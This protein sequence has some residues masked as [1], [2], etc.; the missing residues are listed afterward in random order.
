MAA[1]PILNFARWYDRIFEGTLGSLREIAARAVPPQEGIQIL[2]IGCGTGSQLAIYNHA[3]CQIYGIDLSQ[4]MLRIAKSKLGDRA[5]LTMGDALQLPH[6]EQTFDLVISSLFIHQ[7]DPGQRSAMLEEAVRVLRPGGQILLVDFH[8][9]ERR[10]I[11]GKFTYAFISMIEFFAGWEHFS[12][13]RDFLAKGG[14]PPIADHMGLRVRKSFV[15][16]YGNLGV[17]LLHRDNLGN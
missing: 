5:G 17:Y 9:Q 2:D 10:S 6:Q 11:S 3:G 12:N 14:I 15:V 8:V 7:L 1:E 16:G 4:P 13:S